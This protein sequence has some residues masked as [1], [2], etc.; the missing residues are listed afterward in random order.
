MRLDKLLQN[1]EVLQS[2]CAMDTEITDIVFDSR[3]AA[4]GTA[5]VAAR[6][7]GA[8]GHD[9]LDAAVENGA[10]VVVAE[11][12]VPGAPFVVVPDGNRDRKSVV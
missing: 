4:P 12:E 3:R 1:V 9:Y 5:Y 10:S 7:I 11:R 2:D 8:N 6:R